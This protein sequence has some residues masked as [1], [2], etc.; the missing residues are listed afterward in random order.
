MSKIMFAGASGTGKS[1]L[2]EWIVNGAELFSSNSISFVSGSVSDLLPKTKICLIRICLQE[3]P[4]N[5]T[6]R[7]CKY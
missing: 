6:M 2:A 7:I 5:Y 4:W 3:I 1:T